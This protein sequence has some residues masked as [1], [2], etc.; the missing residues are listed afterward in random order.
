MH[1]KTGKTPFLLTCHC[2]VSRCA[3]RRGNPSEMRW[4]DARPAPAQ[5]RERLSTRLMG[6]QTFWIYIL[7]SGK[8][9]TL[10]VGVTNSLQTRLWQHKQHKGG[11]FTQRYRI[12][13]LVYFEDF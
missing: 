3:G 7:A 1:S 9:G 10:Y 6:S 8:N 13:Q 12:D 5:T 2:E 11:G 4:S